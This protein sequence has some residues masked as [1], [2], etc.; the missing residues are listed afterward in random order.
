MNEQ[1]TGGATATVFRYDRPELGG[2]SKRI[3]VLGRTDISIGC[4]Q[5]VA[6]GGENNLHS[7]ATLDGYWFVLAGRARFYTTGDELIADVGRHEGVLVP[8]GYPYWFESSGD[9]PLELLQFEASSA[10]PGGDLRHDRIDHE[11]QKRA[12]I[13]LA[14]DDGR[15]S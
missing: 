4:V 5:V 10:G 12:T 6:D 7:H 15:A 8:R 2:R 1:P 13:D 11:P 3:V 9:V 14:G